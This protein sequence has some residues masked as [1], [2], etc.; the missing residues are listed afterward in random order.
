MSIARLPTELW[1]GAH[2]RQVFAAGNFAAV[3]RKG[4]PTGGLVLLKLNLL[5][6]TIRVLRQTRDTD[7]TLAWE[8]ALEG[9]AVPEAEANHYIDRQIGYDPD[10]W[11]IEV[12]DRAG[13]NPFEGRVL[14]EK[15]ETWPW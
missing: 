1:V 4:D 11:V 9:R 8:K 5:D 6:G 10:L 15:P 2:I 12:E 7:G 14:G 13:Q 3:V